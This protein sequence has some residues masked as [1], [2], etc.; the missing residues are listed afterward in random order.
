MKVEE[1]LV[2]VVDFNGGKK[3]QGNSRGIAVKG[4]LKGI[5]KTLEYKINSELKEI[6]LKKK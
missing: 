5:S 3:K 1:F 6:W 4:G 2:K